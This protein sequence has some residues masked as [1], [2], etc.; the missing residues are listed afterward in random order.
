MLRQHQ[1]DYLIF[2]NSKII[3]CLLK[4][5]AKLCWTVFLCLGMIDILPWN[6][7]SVGTSW[8]LAWW[9]WMPNNVLALIPVRWC[10]PGTKQIWLVSDPT[11]FRSSAI[12]R[13][14]PETEEENILQTHLYK[15]ITKASLYTSNCFGI[16]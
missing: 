9:W 10:L 6:L 15:C 3:L 8:T 14:R 16:G 5:T 11:L 2:L 13:C 7:K 12:G 1:C 4:W